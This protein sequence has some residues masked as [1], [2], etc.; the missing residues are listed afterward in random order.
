M[1]YAIHLI[2][3]NKKWCRCAGLTRSEMPV[4]F[5]GKVP[6]PQLGDPD[7]VGFPAGR[8]RATATAFRRRRRDGAFAL[9]PICACWS[10]NPACSSSPACGP[11]C[12]RGRQTTPPRPCTGPP[13]ERRS[14]SRRR[15]S[16]RLADGGPVHLAREPSRGF[17]PR[18]TPTERSRDWTPCLPRL[19][20]VRIL[21]RGLA[22]H[23]SLERLTVACSPLRLGSAPGSE[24]AAPR[25]VRR[26]AGP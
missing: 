2:L 20:V 12:R 8:C 15:R 24:S 5:S 25:S 11:G 1:Q 4:F 18:S 9:E 17:G 21:P 14:R 23:R 6:K 10:W 7:F 19:R 3:Q 26:R 13:H 22:C 16:F